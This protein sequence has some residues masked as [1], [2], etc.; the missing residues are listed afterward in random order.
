M[1]T[2]IINFKRWLY[3]FAVKANT[4]LGQNGRSHTKVEYQQVPVHMAFIDIH[5]FHKLVLKILRTA[6]SH[7][8][9]SINYKFWTQWSIAYC[10]LRKGH[11]LTRENW[12]LSKKSCDIQ[13]RDPQNLN[14]ESPSKWRLAVRKIVSLLERARLLCS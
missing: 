13:N 6:N 7:I 12:P 14:M 9:K 1:I 11:C 8:P 4:S 3:L 2:S 5:T 10:P